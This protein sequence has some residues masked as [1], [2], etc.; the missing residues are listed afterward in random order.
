MGPDQDEGYRMD[1]DNELLLRVARLYHVQAETMDAIAN[2]LGVSRS[3][4]SR[5]LKD[6]RERGLVRVT[7]VDPERPM[8]R[9]AELFRK[10]FRVNAHLVHVRAGASGVFRLDQVAKVAAKLIDETVRDEDTV[11][12]AW[13]TTTSAIAVQLRPRDLTGVTVVGMNG[14]ANHRTTGLPY[15]G[16]ILQR[17]ATAFRGEEQLFTLPA[18]FDDPATK[19]AMWRERSTQHVLKVR[20]RSRLAVFGVGGLG[21]ELQSHVYASNYL[22]VEDL[23]EL[24]RNN[25]VGDVCTV[26]LRED[27]SWRDIAFNERA[28]G[29]TPAEL[30]S[31]P[32]RIC[33]VSGQ[34][35]AAPVLG[36]LRAGVMTDLVIDDETARAV[37]RRMQPNLR[38]D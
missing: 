19:A 13:G 1:R 4:V 8:T 33:V 28:T 15:V 3:T 30:R 37:L 16:S 38:M 11:G 5:L 21:A 26:M 34:S 23:A 20:S 24:A 7:I 22:D 31:I 6:A 2:Q 10:N 25:V 17:F 14:G 18:F 9:L 12:V 35:K 36:A 27:G 29:M 32:R